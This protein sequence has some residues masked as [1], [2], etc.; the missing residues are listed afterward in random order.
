MR[1]VILLRS[2][3]W[4]CLLGVLVLSLMPPSPEMPTTGWD[5]S[6]HLLGFAMPMLLGRWAYAGRTRAMVIGLMA[7]GALIEVLQSLTPY[8]F[9]EWADLLADG[10]GLF[11]GWAIGEAAVWIASRR[12]AGGAA[13]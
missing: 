1:P 3:F 6:N 5:K 13:K 9:A 7:F 11:C 2:A 12:D 4:S 10:V 8:R